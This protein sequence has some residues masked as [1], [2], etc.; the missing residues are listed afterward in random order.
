M[1]VRVLLV[2]SE[3]E[4]AG[5]IQRALTAA[6]MTV[7]R[8]RAG[9]EA[10]R[11]FRADAVDVL[12]VGSLLPGMNGVDVCAA[13]RRRPGTERLGIVLMSA[14]FRGSTA[15][16]DAYREAGVDAFFHKPFV[17]EELVEGLFA[18]VEHKRGPPPDDGDLL[19]VTDDVVVDEADA[20]FDGGPVGAS[21]PRTAVV[22]PAQARA[23]AAPAA[24]VAPAAASTRPVAPTAS[25]RAAPAAPPPSTSPAPA[26]PPLPFAEYGLRTPAYEVVEP[27]VGGAI[28]NHVD[29]ARAALG[30]ARA[31]ATGVLRLVDGPSRMDLA[32]LKGVVVGGWDNLREHLLGERL[33]RRGILT[34]DQMRRLNER[35]ATKGERVAEA[36]LALGLCDARTALSHIEEQA[37]D[38][39][40]RALAWKGGA[41]SF[42]T[43]VQQ[44]DKLAVASVDLLEEVVLYGLLPVNAALAHRFL[45]ERAGHRVLRGADFD[46]GLRIYA[47]AKPGSPLLQALARGEGET[48][49][50]LVA[51]IVHAGGL[52]LYALWLA[53]VVRTEVD[54]V[55]GRTTPRPFAGAEAAASVVDMDAVATVSEALL[56]A[57]G[58]TFYELLGLEPTA[59][60]D[61][62]ARALDAA[63]AAY[64]PERLGAA[65]L[66]P[67]RAAARELWSILD[68]ARL[69]L[70]DP[71]HRAAYDE[72]VLST[73][74]AAQKAQD[75]R[76]EQDF[77][78]GQ[79]SLSLGDFE[80]AREA[81]ERAVAA[82]PNDAEYVA[83]LGWA[84]ILEGR[85]PLT[86]GIDLLH[87]ALRA[88]PQ[89]MRPV[90]FMGLAAQ[91]AG[92]V[93]TARS[94]MEEAHRRAPDDPDVKAALLALPPRG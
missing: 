61:E 66:G 90:F 12:L 45:V 63:R 6:G 62:I 50:R 93:E 54:L 44:V 76:P 60:V 34:A 42:A 37:R 30:V 27:V 53:G 58:R 87:R 84:T 75:F 1:N 70:L 40:R 79:M 47:R 11:A 86:V 23:G 10:L 2:E 55:E 26:S 82:R 41:A 8:T 20:L 17:L 7:A 71:E 5:A 3:D 33:W 69:V 19:D 24:P 89:S 52:D 31:R 57:R 29:V 48:I 59:S 28:A 9:D 16:R 32:F 81:F 92:D 21:T 67:A 18:L 85:Q 46:E 22:A 74:I 94:W 4:F 77:L 13:V 14:A 78:D 39:V 64:G 68:E 36:L 35:I 49:E 80:S 25:T 72:D 56:R 83:F 88:N 38:R 65:R 43:G 73:R 51:P 15:M 91:Q